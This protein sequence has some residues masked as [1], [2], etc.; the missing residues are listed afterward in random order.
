MRNIAPADQARD[1]GLAFYSEDEL[2]AAYPSSRVVDGVVDYGDYLLAVEVTGGQTVLDTR[3][4]GDPDKFEADTNKLVLNKV[5]QLHDLCRSLLDDQSRLTGYPPSPRQKI[6]PIL[7]VGGG[8]PADA[9]SR[10]HVED[11]LAEEGLLQDDALLPLCILDPTEV[12]ILETLQDSGK[13]PAWVL[14]AWKRSGLRNVGFKNYVVKEVD[15]DLP[16][17]VNHRKRA[18]IAYVAAAERLAGEPLPEGEL[19]RAL[20]DLED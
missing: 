11:K 4:S 3:V 17:P 1:S 8:Y 10:S 6:V 12:E 14:A 16:T 18:A 13:S 5:N 15:P 7:V 19:Q 2:N 20:T 9:L